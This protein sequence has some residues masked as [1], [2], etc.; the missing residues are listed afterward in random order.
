MFGWM[1]QHI[2]VDYDAILWKW[3]NKTIIQFARVYKNGVKQWEA[4]SCRVLSE[5]TK[6]MKAFS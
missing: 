1:D 6:E 2:A 5:R 4:K 3:W